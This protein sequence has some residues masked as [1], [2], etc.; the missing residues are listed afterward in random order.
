[1]GLCLQCGKAEADEHMGICPMCLVDLPAYFRKQAEQRAVQAALMK[2]A[3]MGGGSMG[4]RWGERQYQDYLRK[5]QEPAKREERKVKKPTGK[6][7]HPIK[8][9]LQFELP[10]DLCPMVNG[11]KGL[12]NMH[13]GAVRR[14]KR[15]IAEALAVQI[16]NAS[17]VPFAKAK[18]E[19]IRK[20]AKEPDKDN[21][22]GAV[23]PIL[24]AMQVVSKRHPYGAYII[25]NDDPDHIELVVRWE[26]ASP[27]HGSVL[28]I[29]TPIPTRGT[30][31]CISS[32]T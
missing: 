5:Q 20:T 11:P 19:I 25:E 7:A 6:P 3:F 23:K 8:G 27:N 29:V 32:P 24:D 22:Y 26:K 16:P 15:K 12:K 13:W 2:Q 4:I 28:I 21:L 18:V 9:S 14:L 17:G 31:Q 10:I 1:M 30:K